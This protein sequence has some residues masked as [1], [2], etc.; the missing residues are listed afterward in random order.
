MDLFLLET[1]ITLIYFYL[2]L[3]LPKMKI[4]PTVG[5]KVPLVSPEV[6]LTMSSNQRG[7]M[8]VFRTINFIV[9]T[10]IDGSIAVYSLGGERTRVFRGH[11]S[12]VWNMGHLLEDVLFSVDTSM[13]I[14]SWDVSTGEILCK[15]QV[16]SEMTTIS[17]I[18]KETLVFGSTQAIIRFFSH[19][20]GRNMKEIRTL[21]NAQAEY[22]IANGAIFVTHIPQKDVYVRDVESGQLIA[23]L[24]HDAATDRTI[25]D[26]DYIYTYA[27]TGICYIHRN[28][29]G[30]PL[31][32]SLDISAIAENV[33]PVNIEEI[34]PINPNLMA[35]TMEKGGIYFISYEPFECRASFAPVGNPRVTSAFITSDVRICVVND[36]DVCAIFPVPEKVRADVST[37]VDI[38]K[39]ESRSEKPTAAGTGAVNIE[40]EGITHAQITS[41]E[42]PLTVA[43]MRKEMQLMQAE[44]EAGKTKADKMQAEIEAGKK[45]ADDMRAEIEVGKKKADEME[46]A[47]ERQNIEMEKMKKNYE[48][49]CTTQKLELLMADQMAELKAEISKQAAD[50]HAPNKRTHRGA[51]GGGDTKKRNLNREPSR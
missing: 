5:P 26:D 44:L 9:G 17:I 25:L 36:L 18:G 2:D 7:S 38:M 51:D 8:T 20:N 13:N 31:F 28:A 47:M 1:N 34:D 41:P 39:S 50:V 46:A 12:S 22:A 48:I 3:S 4:E 15:R 10:G 30:Y 6:T 24:S 43:I 33:Y 27:R 11:S 35:V 37:Y 16:S 29:P 49:R 23:R 14:I 32:K 21:K 40:G 45:K 19:E 42:E